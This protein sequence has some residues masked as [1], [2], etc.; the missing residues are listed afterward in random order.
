M[1][2]SPP[3]HTRPPSLGIYIHPSDNLNQSPDRQSEFRTPKSAQFPLPEILQYLT[4]LSV[5]RALRLSSSMPYTFETLPFNANSLAFSAYNDSLL[6]VTSS[7]NFGLVGNGRL[8][9]LNLS[10]TGI[11]AVNSYL[12]R[13]SLEHFPRPLLFLAPGPLLRFLFSFFSRFPASWEYLLLALIQ[14]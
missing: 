10:P 7:Q 4:N 14:V 11:N 13:E 9:I 5:S 8:H 3:S 2:T 6:A 1:P 12:P